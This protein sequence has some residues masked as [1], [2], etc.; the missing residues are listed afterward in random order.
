M[1]TGEPLSLYIR[2]KNSV[3][4]FCDCQDVEICGRSNPAGKAF[5]GKACRISTFLPPPAAVTLF[6]LAR[7][8]APERG[9][10]I[11]SPAGARKPAVSVRFLS[12]SQVETA[13]ERS[14]PAV[15]SLRNS[16]TLKNH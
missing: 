10:P 13:G 5:Q 1:F 7:Y 4:W 12:D 8:T 16:G 2:L 6:T 3:P 14:R 9:S 15:T 11:I